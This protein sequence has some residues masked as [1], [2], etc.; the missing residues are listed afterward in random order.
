MSEDAPP[1]A[2]GRDA[3]SAHDQHQQQIYDQLS[4]SASRARSGL[5]FDGPK[6]EFF[7]ASVN[8]PQ[9]QPDFHQ[10]VDVF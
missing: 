5:G 10:L 6:G 9:A 3:V 7:R 1:A 8:R 4:A 2:A